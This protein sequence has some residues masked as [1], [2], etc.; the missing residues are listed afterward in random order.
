LI[1]VVHGKAVPFR[2]FATVPHAEIFPESAALCHA[3]SLT[4]SAGAWFHFIVGIV[5]RPLMIETTTTELAAPTSDDATTQ[6][7]ARLHDLLPFTIGDQTFAVFTDQ[8]DATAD[9]RPVAPLPKAPAA[10]VGVVCVRGRMVTVLDAA[11]ILN[12]AQ[13]Q[14]PATLPF[15]LVLRGDDQVGI[16]A[17]TIRDTVTISAEDIEA[18]DSTDDPNPPVALG[19]VTYAGERMVILDAV[20]LFRRAVQRRERRRRRF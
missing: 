20:R 10:V 6:D 1:E 16:V 8:I 14:W 11:A 9:A 5:H 12:G 3:K 19:A 4:A 13:T 17:D 7:G 15:V 2:F 18:T